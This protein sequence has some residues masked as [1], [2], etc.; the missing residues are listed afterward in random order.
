MLTSVPEQ[1]A[2][3]QYVDNVVSLAPPGESESTIDTATCAC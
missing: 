2:L 3:S 1:P